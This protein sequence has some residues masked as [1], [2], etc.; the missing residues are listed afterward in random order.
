[1]GPGGVHDHQATTQGEGQDYPA[2]VPG[3]RW[4][5]RHH[6]SYWESGCC[7]VCGAWAEDVPEYDPE[8]KIDGDYLDSLEA[9]SIDGPGF[10]ETEVDWREESAY[11]L[12]Y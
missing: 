2:T 6:D 1:M 9:A 4:V 11:G 10:Y 3:P 5:A 12:G 8:D 7:D